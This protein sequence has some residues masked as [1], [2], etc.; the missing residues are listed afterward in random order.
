[1]TI[2]ATYANTSTTLVQSLSDHTLEI[3][4]TGNVFPNSS[5]AYATFNTAYAADTYGGQPYP[6]VTITGA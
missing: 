5:P 6:I 4:G 2:T 3:F 1:M